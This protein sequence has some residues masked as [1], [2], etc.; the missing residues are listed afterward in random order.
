M[1]T[2]ASISVGQIEQRGRLVVQFLE[3][4]IQPLD[5]LHVLDLGC[6]SGDISTAI[7]ASGAKLTAT[8]LNPNNL[9]RTR[10]RL[11]ADSEPTLCASS[12]LSLPFSASQFDLVLLNG[13]LEWV[14]KANFEE[15]PEVCQLQALQEVYRTLKP[16]GSLYVA[17]ENRY[18]PYWLLGDP[19]IALPLVAVLPRRLADLIHRALRG[20]PYVTYIHSAPESCRR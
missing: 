19:H 13:V 12:A 5:H 3:D 16:G 20:S 1:K 4:E 18:Y 7:D 14:G 10:G 11:Q 9:R 15:N 6:G 17:I 8:D 2:N